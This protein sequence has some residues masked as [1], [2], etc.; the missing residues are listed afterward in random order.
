MELRY[1]LSCDSSQWS[2]L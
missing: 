1:G 2:L